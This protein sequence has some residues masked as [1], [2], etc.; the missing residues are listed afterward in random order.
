M[1]PEIL[2]VDNDPLVCGLSNEILQEAGFTTQMLHDGKLA[3]AA[4]REMRP[5]AVLLDILMPGIDGLSI[6]RSIKSDAA[7]KATKVIIVSGKTFPTEK[8]RASRYGADLFIEKPYDV[9]A[10]AQTVMRVVGRPTTPTP[11]GT[12][13]GRKTAPVRLRVWGSRAMPKAPQ[14]ASARAEHTPCVSLETEKHFFIFDAGSGLSPLGRELLRSARKDLWIFLTHFHEGHLNGLGTFPCS[15]EASYNLHICGPND[16]DKTLEQCVRDIFKNSFSQDPKPIR[17]KIQLLALSEGEHDILPGVRLRAFY[18][19]HPSTTLGY[20]M[21]VAGKKIVYCPD[22][23]L[24]GRAT[25][26]QDYDETLGNACRNADILIHDAYYKPE[27]HARHKNEGHSSAFEAAEFA[28][29]FEAERLLL[30]HLDAS[31]SP[32]TLR[33]LEREVQEML[34]TKGHLLECAIAWEG[35]EINI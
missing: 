27:D 6:C 8:E 22:S 24:L 26:L 31:Y 17:A 32:E 21:E 3:I 10:F 35:L 13:P 28:A 30:F 20:S 25:A 4:I 18:T 16:P 12:T 11:A 1:D 33:V 5:R 29:R 14:E 9:D 15:R 7:L 19:N 23:E 34:K 2:I